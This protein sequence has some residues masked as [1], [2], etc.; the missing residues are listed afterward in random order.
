LTALAGFTPQ[1]QAAE[2][3]YKTAIA[4]EPKSIIA[5]LGLANFYLQSGKIT[6]AEREFMVAQALEPASF[7][8]KKCV[9]SESNFHPSLNRDICPTLVQQQYA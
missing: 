7:I 1:A 2:A 8:L 6:E 9:T 4:M 3:A 5:H